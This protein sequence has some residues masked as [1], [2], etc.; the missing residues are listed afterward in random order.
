[1]KAKMDEIVEFT[2]LA[3]YLAM[4]LRTY[5]TSLPSAWRRYGHLD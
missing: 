1:M 4:P 2:K 5:P 3:Y